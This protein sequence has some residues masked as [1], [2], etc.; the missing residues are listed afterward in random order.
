MA[1]V[2][3]SL[4]KIA[5][6]RKE[7]SIAKLEIKSSIHL[8]G[9]SKD[10]LKLI[11]NKDTLK[12][13]FEY[14]LE[15]AP[16]LATIKFAG[17]ILYAADPSESDNIIKEFKK[18]GKLGKDLQTGIYNFIFQR[19]NI[20]ALQLEQELSLPAHIRLPYLSLNEKESKK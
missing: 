17:I 15:Y 6:E 1:A 18:S 20:K 4:S 13:N 10:K 16:N 12:I 7:S 8:S 19:C 2:G 11:A 14:N 3:F 9:V 5:L